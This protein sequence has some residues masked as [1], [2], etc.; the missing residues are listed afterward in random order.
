MSILAAIDE[1]ERSKTVAKIASDLAETYND[2]LVA[3]HVV[4]EEGFDSHR[5]SLQS[6]PEFQN[7]SI[8]QEIESGKKFAKRF[9]QESVDNVDLNKLEARGRVGNPTDEI[10]AE[11]ASL[12]PRF[13]VIS[14]RRRSPTGKAVF[15]NTAQQI[16]LNAECPVVTQL[17]D[18]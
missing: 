6:I 12:E 1:N 7:Y 9:V 2:T 17:S 5:N 13:L 4:P 18:K 11:T 14:G 15:G 8:T 10:L 3:L 16:L